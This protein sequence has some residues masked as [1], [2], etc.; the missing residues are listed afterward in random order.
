MTRQTQTMDAPIFII[1]TERSGTNLLRLMLNAHSAIAVPHPPHIVKLFAPLAPGYGDLRRDD[2]FRRLVADVCR[3]VELHPYP[4]GFRPDRE[5]A[6]RE[7]PGRELLA[8][9]LAV[10]DQYRTFTGKRR[11]CCKSTFMIDQVAAILRYR[12]DARFIF[13]VRDPRDVAVSAKKSIFNHFHVYYTARRWQRE[14]RLGLQWLVRLPGEQIQ[15]L[16]Y[17][18]LLA[19]P[20][21]TLRRL[22]RFLGEE[23]EAPML[24]YHRS[25]E[26]QKSGSLCIS[27]E[28]TSRPVLRHNTEKFRG[29]LTREEICLIEALCR[30]EMGELGYELTEGAVSAARQAELLRPRPSYRVSE[31][32]LC[33]RAEARHL[34]KD[35]NSLLRLKKLLFLKYLGLR[36]KVVRHA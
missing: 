13:M 19:D 6:F 20:E 10:Y 12:P 27:W 8:V 32:L 4:W 5:Q 30:D 26:A 18:E 31:T 21:G 9:Y 15:L 25:A 33:L 22:C 24:A 2:N 28:N 7:A 35:R 23:F 16:Q 34:V 36:Q 17:E 11:W 29:R 3:L 1:G 14:Q